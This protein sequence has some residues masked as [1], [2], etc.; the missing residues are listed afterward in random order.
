MHRFN[1]LASHAPDTT[2]LIN[3]INHDMDW[4]PQ[5]CASL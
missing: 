4:Y 1:H 2:V 3:D 5:F